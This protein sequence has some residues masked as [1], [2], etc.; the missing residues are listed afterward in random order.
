MP[1][2]PEVYPNYVEISKRRRLTSNG[3]HFLMNKDRKMRF[4]PYERWNALVF[5][6]HMIF[7]IIISPWA[8]I[9][10]TVT[11]KVFPDVYFSCIFF[12]SLKI[13]LTKN[14]EEGIFPPIFPGIFMHQGTYIQRIREGY[15][16]TIRTSYLHG[17][18]IYRTTI[19]K[20]PK[21]LWVVCPSASIYLYSV[22]IHIHIRLSI[23]LYPAILF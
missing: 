11:L 15:R 18:P 21:C 6:S 7:V 20:V 14:P 23:Q 4:P 22:S 10:E 1:H 17:V 19:F 16:R 3:S 2:P 9:D 12:F 5:G 13:I 8:A